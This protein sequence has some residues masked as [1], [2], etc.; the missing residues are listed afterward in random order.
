RWTVEEFLQQWS[1]LGVF[2]TIIATGAGLPMPEEL[3]VVLGGAL[4]GAGHAYMWLMLPTCIVAVIIGDGVLYGIGRMWGPRL[5]ARPFTKKHFLPPERLHKIEDNSQKYGTP[6]LLF[7]PPPP[8]LRPPI[9]PPAGI[10]RLPLI[11]FLI[12]DGIYAIPGVSLL[13]F[14]GYA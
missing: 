14:L 1:Y 6:L 8:G 12:A 10:V 13:F 2:L 3:P 11:R 4:V 7:A 9:F 5:L